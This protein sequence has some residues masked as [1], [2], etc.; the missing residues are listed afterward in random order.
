MSD[1]ES[2]AHLLDGMEKEWP[3]FKKVL[4]AIPDGEMDRPGV[5]D[6][7]CLKEL[8][9]HVNF[10]AEKGARDVRLAGEGK[11]DQIEVPGGQEK[12]D[13]WNAREAALGKAKTP[14]ELR[15]A[16][17]AS[18]ENARRALEEAPEP[19]LA[20]VL[21]GWSVGVRYAED[22]YRHYREHAEQ[23]RAWGRD[24]ETSEA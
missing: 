6:Q 8:L 12:V 16:V 7:W 18:Y 5:V 10:W 9:G 3:A 17:Q 23:I 2:K 22:T 1:T 15:R 21:E 24:L 13:E 19:A 11:A 20:V 4:D 14:A